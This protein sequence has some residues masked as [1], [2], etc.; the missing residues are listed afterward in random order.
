MVSMAIVESIP[1]APGKGVPAPMAVKV[2][3]RMTDA[4]AYRP[5]ARTAILAAG[6]IDGAP[7]GSI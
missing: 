6:S 3:A 4:M 2:Q 1:D 5:A 7:R